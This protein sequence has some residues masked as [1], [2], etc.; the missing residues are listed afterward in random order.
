MKKTLLTILQVAV[1]LGMLAWVL[2][3]P[4]KRADMLNA[5]GGAELGWLFF[6][7]LSYGLLGGVAS[8]RWQ[9]LLRVQGIT[10]GFFRVA[11]LVMIGIFFNLFMPGGTGGDVVKV[12]YLLK[13]TP[14]KTGQALLAVLIDRVIGLLGI[15]LLALVVLWGKYEWLQQTPATKTLTLS[16]LVIMGSSILGVLFSF[17]ITGFGLASKL[18]ERMPFRD[19][20]IDLSIAYHQYAKAWKT[21][22]LSLGLSLVVHLCSFFVFYAAARSLHVLIPLRDFFAVMPIIN[23]LSALPISVGGTGVREGLFET[24]LPSLCGIPQSA[25]VLVSLTGYSI[26]VAWG[27]IG[28]VIYL[29]YRP[30]EHARLREIEKTV[31]K[32]E[33]DIADAE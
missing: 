33:H 4:E 21:S 32:L 6:G 27:I 7:F 16:L 3:S 8:Y 28:C 19:K 30:S 22:L 26:V 2:R 9:L 15:F 18:P 12:F 10:L 25:A 29:F 13:E 20:L 1:T 23:T 31:K 5:L 24:L 17:L 14:G 11:A